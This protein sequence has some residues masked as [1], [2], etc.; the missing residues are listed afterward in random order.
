MMKTIALVLVALVCSLVST[1]SAALAQRTVLNV[2]GEQVSIHRDEYGVPHI[3][4][5][6]R[7]ALF[8]AYGYVVAQDRLWQLEINRHA[9]RGRLAEL[10]GPGTNPPNGNI[11]ADQTAR[12]LGYTDA[13][14][15][16]Q[17][18]ALSV[19]QQ[20][21]FTAYVEGINRY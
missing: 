15:A 11:V 4:A 20:E 16:Q 12:R 5:E 1:V 19:A 13:E 7:R 14:L 17:F 10:L 2:D 9:A 6:T 3:F 21:V 18:A 8:K